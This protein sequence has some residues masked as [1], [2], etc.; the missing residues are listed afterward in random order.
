MHE[1]KMPLQKPPI[2]PSPHWYWNRRRIGELSE[3]IKNYSEEYCKPGND[4]ERDRE[5]L[6]LINEW[7]TEISLICNTEIE[8][9]KIHVR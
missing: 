7:A 1:L 6:Q 5:I 4:A 2:G 3:C 8:L 9:N